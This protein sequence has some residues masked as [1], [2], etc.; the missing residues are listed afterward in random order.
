MYVSR[1]TLIFSRVTYGFFQE[2]SKRK[3]RRQLVS[4]EDLIYNR[5]QKL[6]QNVIH[7]EAGLISQTTRSG[8][9]S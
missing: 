5:N 9:I 1:L 8:L 4:F 2:I 6:E 7:T 3:Q